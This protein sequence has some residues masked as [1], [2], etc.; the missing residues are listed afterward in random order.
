M[1]LGPRFKIDDTFSLIDSFNKNMGLNH[2]YYKN[3]YQCLLYEMYN[4]Y[5]VICGNRQASNLATNF[6]NPF[7]S[8]KNKSMAHIVN[9]IRRKFS[10]DSSSS[11]SIIFFA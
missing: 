2:F 8:S 6:E 11:S 7:S 3:N 5:N 10:S 9:M 1:I 4:K